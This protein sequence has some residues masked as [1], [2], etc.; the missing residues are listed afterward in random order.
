MDVDLFDYLRFE[1]LH[2]K[3]VETISYSAKLHGVSTVSCSCRFWDSNSHSKKR[4]SLT[5]EGATI[6]GHFDSGFDIYDVMV[7][8]Q[9]E[10]ICI[11]LTESGTGL[12][13]VIHCT[14]AVVR[15]SL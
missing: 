15:I 13:T 10:H 7:D 6:D 12:V 3:V 14:K 2:D 11:S 4:I 1:T 8:Q 9:R 5:F